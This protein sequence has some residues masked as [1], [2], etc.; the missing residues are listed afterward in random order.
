MQ[1]VFIAVMDN[2]PEA[3]GFAHVVGVFDAEDL[4]RAACQEEADETARGASREAEPLAW[5]DDDG[6]A[7]SRE[8]GTYVVIM[9]DLNSRIGR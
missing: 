5:N 2:D 7:E 6:S 1:D 8:G 9:N 3:H 4:A